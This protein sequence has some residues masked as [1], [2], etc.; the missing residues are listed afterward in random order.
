MSN[1]EDEDSLGSVISAAGLSDITGIPLPA[2][3]KRSL[4]RALGR[5]IN[6]AVDVPVAY[7]E[8]Q[9]G[10]IRAH[11]KGTEVVTLAAAAAAAQRFGSDPS[12]VDRAT[13]HFGAKIVREQLNREAVARAT[14]EAIA[15]SP[16]AT[17]AE[18]EVDED[19]LTEFTEI[20]AKKSNEEIRV[21]L[22]R[23]LAG[24]ITKPGTFSPATL[25]FLT[26][27]S[28]STA[29]KFQLLSGMSIT[30]EEGFTYVVTA[31]F[32]D[33][34]QKGLEGLGISYGDVLTLQSAGLLTPALTSQLDLNRYINVALADYVG[35]PFVLRPADAS[36]KM[37][38]AKITVFS[39]IGHE[40][41]SVIPLE[42]NDA[43]DAKLQKW[44]T[45]Q[46]VSIEIVKA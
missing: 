28:K 39:P 30:D 27:L 16:P 8:T 12:L 13:N 20:A 45:S 40:L 34:E 5:L 22:G 46:S 2:P 11:G 10:K 7:F 35:Q 19:W 42:R 6:G 26:T 37:A 9:A 33:F 29:H 4:W 38:T 18:G 31:P 21:I 25:Q 44:L 41:R 23:I 1:S 15:L 36:K 32:P 14:V 43:Y 24:E 3:V 17:E